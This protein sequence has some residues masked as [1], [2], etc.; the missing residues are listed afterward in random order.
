MEQLYDVRPLRKTR[1]VQVVRIGEETILFDERL[2]KYYGLGG[3]AEV[4]WDVLQDGDTVGALLDRL[5]ADY[6]LTTEAR[7]YVLTAV[8]MLTEV[9]VLQHGD[10]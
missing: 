4:V 3:A 2:D 7:G 6:D 1:H 8:Q 5:E 10:R 9:G